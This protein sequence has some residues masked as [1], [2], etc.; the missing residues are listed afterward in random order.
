MSTETQNAAVQAAE[1]IIKNEAPAKDEGANKES[2]EASESENTESHESEADIESDPSLS[3]KE[4]I[5]AK[6]KLK[7]LKIK[8]DGRESDEELP[9]EIDDDPAIV[10]YMTKQLQMSKMAQKRAQ[11]KATIEKQVDQVIHLLKT[12][13]RKILTDPAIGIDLKKFAAEIIEEEIQNS[14]KSPEVLEK[15]KIAAELKELKE[16]YE[17]EKEETRQKE[18]ARLEQQEAERYDNAIEKAL[19]GSDLPKSPYVVKK[20]AEYMYHGLKNGV[21][22]SPEDVLPLVREEIQ[23]DL[24]QMFSAMPLDVVEQLVGKDIF[25]KVRQKNLEKVKSTPASVN[26]PIDTGV[27]KKSEPK[28]EVKKTFKQFFGV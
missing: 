21:D 27:S 11:E 2:L 4:K 6:K 20:I 14:Q 16:Q 26:K 1:S 3:K 18:L 28:A 10:D 15:E 5:E 13:P 19:N 9:F 25:K 23:G 12:N 17:R 7:K 22:L 24:Q 8:V